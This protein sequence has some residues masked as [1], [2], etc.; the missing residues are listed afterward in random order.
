[1]V[2]AAGI[3]PHSH[4]VRASGRRR[5]SPHPLLVA[6]A[7]I[8]LNQSFAFASPPG[9]LSAWLKAQDATLGAAPGTIVIDQPGRIDSTI[10]LAPGHSLDLRASV[11]WAATVRLSGDNSVGCTGNAAT[12]TAHLPPFGFGGATG[13][14]LLS[15]GGA[16]IRISGCHVISD[17]PS[18][19]L[20]GYPVS[21]LEMSGNTLSGLMLLAVNGPPGSSQRLTLS[22][23]VVTSSKPGAKYAGMQLNSAKSVIATGNS[24]TNLMHG[25]M[26]WGGDAGAPGANLNHLNSTGQMSFI[27]NQ[28]KDIGGSCIWGSMGYDIIMRGNSADSCGDVCF[29]AEGGLRTQIVQNKAVGCNNGCAGVFFFTKDTTISGN[30]FR[31]QAPGGGL[32]FIKNSSQ[33]PSAHDGI[34]ITDNELRCEPNLC[35]VVYQEAAGG[36]RFSGN[37][38]TNGVW[39]PIAYARSVSITNNHLIYTKALTGVPAA[40]WMPGIIGGTALEVTGN[41]IESNTPQPPGSACLAAGWSDFNATDTHVI[42]NNTCAGTDPFSIGLTVVS[43]GANPGVAGVWIVSA[44]HFGSA[45]ISNT[46]KTP[47]ERFFDLGQCGIDGC[48]SNP[49]ALDQV[50]SLPGCSGRAPAVSAGSMP[51]CLGGVHGWGA[52]LLPR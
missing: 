48:K 21:D 11:D 1:M 41:R 51:V 3:H 27:G 23:N 5:L 22:K 49:L 24:F 34:S 45:R 33:N 28:C 17:T 44:N 8:F 47:N 10:T 35:R 43:E 40:L 52:V 7:A 36:I 16:H 26:W 14:L 30:H 19:L 46:A 2:E 37:E 6:F 15:E 12:V 4:P 32:I 9:N 38:V 31:A 18:L 25:A 13:M 39:L 20:A 50:R 42:A 29:D